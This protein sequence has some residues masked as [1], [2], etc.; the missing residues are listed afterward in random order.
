MLVPSMNLE[1]IK[2]EIAKDFSV[3]FRKATYLEKELKHNLKHRH[4]EKEIRFH[5]YLSKYKN[6]WIIR[7]EEQKK[8]S[9]VTF[10]TWYYN[11]TGLTAIIPVE[12]NDYLSFYTAGFFKSFNERMQL[13]LTL[14]NDIIRAYADE[15]LITED[16]KLGYCAKG[17]YKFYCHTPHG[18]VLGTCDE[19]QKFYKIY[20]FMTREMLKGRQGELEKVMNEEV[21]KYLER[22]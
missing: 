14:P 11:E 17:I 8:G 18:Y 12:N 9:M 13:N 5:D 21:E 15:N 4:F 3:V 22:T 10:I 1:E 20:A 7:V 19:Y 2:K 16:V 6:N